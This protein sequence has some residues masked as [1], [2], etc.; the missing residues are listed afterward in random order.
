MHGTLGESAWQG[1]MNVS[2]S[3][4]LQ[5]EV[6]ELAEVY[7]PVD[8]LKL[9]MPFFL[10]RLGFRLDEIFPAD[11]PAVAVISGYGLRVRLDRNAKMQPGRLRLRCTTL[12][13]PQTMSS[14][15]GNIIEMVEAN[16]A[17]AIPETTH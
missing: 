4:K 3:S 5:H 16:P 2:K 8:D 12:G 1:E 9:E 10:N 11:D 14:P 13:S 17:L 15:S 6:I 7:L